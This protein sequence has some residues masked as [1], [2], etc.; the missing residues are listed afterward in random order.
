MKQSKLETNKA[1]IYRNVHNDP[2]KTDTDTDRVCTT[3]EVLS[4][5]VRQKTIIRQDSVRLLATVSFHV[6]IVVF[7]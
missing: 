4:V 5:C 2:V 1:Q 7:I 6:V 3:M